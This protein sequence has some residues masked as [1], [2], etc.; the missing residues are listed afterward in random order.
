MNGLQIGRFIAIVVLPIAQFAAAAR[1]WEQ[2]RGLTLCCAE[3]NDL[4]RSLVRAGSGPARVGDAAE[5]IGRAEEGSA[6]LVLADGYPEKRTPLGP[7]LMREARA[8]HL[9]LFI[10][11]PES[12]PG[13]EFGEPRGIR[14]ERAVVADEARAGLPKLRI[15]G[16]HDCR[17]LPA[18]ADAAI[19]VMGRVAG[20]DSAVY[21]LPEER[22][23]VLFAPEEGLL[24]ATTKLSNFASARYAPARDWATLWGHLLDGLDPAGAPHRLAPEPIVRPA[25]GRDEPLPEGASAEAFGRFAA[26]FKKSRLLVSAPREPKTREMLLAGAETTAP[27]APGEPEGDGSLG[28]LEGYASLIHPDGSQDQCTALRADCQAESAAVLALHAKMQRDPRS[29]EIAKNLLDYLYFRS[30]L[31]RRERGDPEHPAFGLIAWGAIAPAWRVANYGDDNA[32]TLLA[33]M[34]AAASLDSDAWDASMLKALLANLR[35]TGALGFRGDRIDIP[36]LERQGWKAYRDARP[37]NYSPPFESYLWACNLWAYARTGDREF[38][39]RTKVAIRMT[40]TA[41]PKGWR[42]G[43]NS[44]RA[45][46]LLPLA[47][48]VRLE[49]TEEHRRWLMRMAGDLIEYQQPCGAIPERL[50]GAGAGHYVVPASNEDYGTSETPILQR[51]GDP[52]SDQLYTSGFALIGLREAVAATGD[53]RLGHAEDLLAEY[54]VRIQNRSDLHPSLDGTWFRAFDYGRWESWASSADKGWGAW[55]AESGW[56]QAWAGI[57]LGLRLGHT[58]LWELTA[59]SKIGLQLPAVRELMSENEG[60]P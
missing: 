6:V 49:D 57:A 50:A 2:P 36:A 44:E 47:W 46:M 27:P 59:S 53:A 56:G 3:D 10:E 52:V 33:T 22:F 9:R 7:D 37:V 11:Y 13:I 20:F 29:R 25:F 31:H 18:K 30:E 48:L 60:G 40:M 14:W 51:N 26:W 54:L 55:S 35:T 5:A 41:Y 32:R 4:Y 21:G 45:R 1:G 23:P 12:L 38:L 16:L 34:L 19:L 24:V 42:W 43:D 8:K 39:D 17:I 15:L 28:I 58:S